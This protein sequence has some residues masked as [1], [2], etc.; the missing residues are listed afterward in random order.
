MI[1]FKEQESMMSIK[2]C[3]TSQTYGWKFPSSSSMYKFV[4][5][6]IPFQEQESLSNKLIYTPDIYDEEFLIAQALCKDYTM[7]ET[8]SVRKLEIHV[9]QSDNHEMKNSE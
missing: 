4:V 2:L 3:H 7:C 6:M 8:T 9:T 5:S 1:P